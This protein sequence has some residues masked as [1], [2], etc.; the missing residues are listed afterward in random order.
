MCYCP[1]SRTSP[2]IRS[3]PP[4]PLIPEPPLVQ[5]HQQHPAARVSTRLVT[6]LQYSRVPR[7]TSIFVSASLTMI[8]ALVSLC[9]AS[10]SRT[11][12]SSTSTTSRSTSRTARTYLVPPSRGKQERR[13]WDMATT[14][15]ACRR[16]GTATARASLV[17]D[18]AGASPAARNWEMSGNMQFRGVDRQRIR[19]AFLGSVMMADNMSCASPFSSSQHGSRHRRT[20]R[21]R[22]TFVVLVWQHLWWRRRDL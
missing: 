14:S 4:W 11:T 12:F 6:L 3:P 1:P 19:R 22:W 2:E 15:L 13:G 9:S 17:T 10:A 18:G 7:R 16:W 20:Q 5:G 21:R 8:H